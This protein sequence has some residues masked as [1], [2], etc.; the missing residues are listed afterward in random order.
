MIYDSAT[1]IARGRVRGGN[2]AVS[3]DFSVGAP[4]GFAV[5]CAAAAGAAVDAARHDRSRVVVT[6]LFSELKF[7][8]ADRGALERDFAGIIAAATLGAAEQ[9]GLRSDGASGA[10]G[11]MNLS[12]IHI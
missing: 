11:G 8:A 4:V 12:L 1:A 6:E 10:D 2:V 3:A 9:A 7:Q 5:L